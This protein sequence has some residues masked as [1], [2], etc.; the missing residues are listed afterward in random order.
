[1]QFVTFMRIPENNKQV[2]IVVYEERKKLRAFN[3]EMYLINIRKF[4][5]FSSKKV[6]NH[7]NMLLNLVPIH[8]SHKIG[9]NIII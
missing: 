2:Q 4:L 1:M 9:V 8:N 3:N 5:T 6:L 7:Y